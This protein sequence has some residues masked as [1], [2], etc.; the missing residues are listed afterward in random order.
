MRL[1]IWT[2][3]LRALALPPVPV[4]PLPAALAA[5]AAAAAGTPGL[6]VRPYPPAGVAPKRPRVDPVW[7]D[8][9]WNVLADPT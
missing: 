9:Y 1:D 7:L 4:D 3:H 8:L 5:W 6:A 2:R